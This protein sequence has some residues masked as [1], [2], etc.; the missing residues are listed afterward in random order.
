MHLRILRR[1]VVALAALLVVAHGAMAQVPSGERTHGQAVI[2]PAYDY[3]TGD[4]VYLSTPQQGTDAIHA[5]ASAVST[6]FLVVYPSSASAA[7]GTMICAHQGGDNCPDHGPGIADLASS[8]VPSVYGAG[9]WGHDHLVEGH[10]GKDFQ[11]AWHVV[12]VLFTSAAAA[13]THITT[14]A[15]LDDALDAGRAITIDTPIV[16]HGNLVSDTVYRL[17]IPEPAVD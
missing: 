4:F 16:I 1:A 5:N 13:E 10:G 12:V 8:V 14:A 15:A 7:V 11:V 9:V 17:A 6:L 3:R 2:E